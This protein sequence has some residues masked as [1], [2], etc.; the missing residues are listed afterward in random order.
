MIVRKKRGSISKTLTYTKICN[1]LNDF[2]EDCENEKELE[3]IN[4]M[5]REITSK[6][7]DEAIEE[8]DNKKRA[9]GN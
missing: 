3:A 7:T 6:M 9:R 4:E 2:Y 8:F 5:V 1:A